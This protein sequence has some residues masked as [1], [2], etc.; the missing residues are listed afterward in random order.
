MTELD[1]ETH[2]AKQAR[3]FDESVAKFWKAFDTKGLTIVFLGI[4]CVILLLM[5][6]C[7]DGKHAKDLVKEHNNMLRA[8]DD[9]VIKYRDINGRLVAKI[10]IIESSEIDAFTAL[11][12]SDEEIIKLQA[13]V[14]KYKGKLYAGSSV[15]MIEAKTNFV[16][17]SRT[18][19]SSNTDTLILDSIMYLYPEYI[20]SDTGRTDTTDWIIINGT[21]SKDYAN[22]GLS[23]V[24]R[25]SVVIGYEG[26]F[27][28]RKPVAIVTNDNP[29]TDIS[30]M[31]TY[32]VS[33]PK[34]RR[35]G[36]GVA[37]GYGAYFDPQKVR[38]GHGFIGGITLNY[39]IIKLK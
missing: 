2:E 8:I 19:L 38:V 9:T 31:R 34:E 15:T 16:S 26:K 10:S 37:V 7:S 18:M 24:N 20:V 39:N 21:V 29:Y 30:S 36:I 22:L 27:K 28:K 1:E 13:E 12:L 4:L 14:K 23:I 3:N 11:H 32:Q 35:L 6:Q 17:D 5:K 33:V 25:Y